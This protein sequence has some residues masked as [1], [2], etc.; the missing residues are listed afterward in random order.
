M[1]LDPAGQSFGV[2]VLEPTDSGLLKATMSHLITAPADWDISKKNCYMAHAVAAIISL[3]K[4]EFVVSEKPWG[5]GFS[6][7]SLTELIGAI[8]AETWDKVVW[9]G[10]SEARRAVVGDGYGNAT[11][12][13]SAEWLDQYPWSPGT[14][15]MIRNLLAAANPETDEGYDILDAIMHGLCFMVSRGIISPKHKEPKKAKK[16][17]VQNAV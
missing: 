13:M 6:K 8:K 16:R 9:Q 17:K 3:E 7:Q 1:A 14:K 10:V 2:V 11:K 5:M 15:T 12:H 4:P